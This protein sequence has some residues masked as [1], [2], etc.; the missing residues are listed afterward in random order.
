LLGLRARLFNFLFDL[1]SLGRRRCA[2]VSRLSL[3]LHRSCCY[4]L[5][6]IFFI[7]IGVYELLLGDLDFLLLRGALFFI[8]TLSIFILIIV[9]CIN[10][11]LELFLALFSFRFYSCLSSIYNTLNLGFFAVLQII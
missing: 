1:G 9:I 11:K 5:F 10:R 7:L 2:I 6:P 4:S 8:T 3:Q